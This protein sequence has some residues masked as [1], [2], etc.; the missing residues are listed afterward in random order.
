MTKKIGYACINMTLS[1]CFVKNNT[2][3]KVSNKNKIFTNRTLRKN[4]FSLEKVSDLILS[5]VKDLYTICNWNIKNNILLFRVSS[6]IFPFMDHPELQYELSELKDY[7]EIS[8]WLKLT[9]DMANSNNLRLT[10]HP[11]PYNCLG[12][13]NDYTVEKTILSLEMHRKLG[14]YLQQDDFVINVHV[15]GT[16]GGDFTNTSMRFCDNFQK[17][18]TQCQKWLTIEN[19]DKQS[20]W[21][22]S[23]LYNYIH[24]NIS[25]PIILDI[26]HW[27][28]CQDESLEKAFEI[29]LSTWGSRKP[30][31]HYS[32][33]ALGKRPQAHSDYI[34]KKIPDF[35]G[36]YDIMIEAK[37][38]EKAVL[39]YINKFQ[40]E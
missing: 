39:D 2:I 34:M 13:P 31:I 22:V 20:M 7:S 36:E 40:N 9:G 29:A 26:H 17:L 3:H 24:K 14:E 6:E 11:G 37:Q 8:N 28:F 27:Q 15:G 16:Y 10:S 33:S 5:N 12:S 25:V 35:G 32:E 4:N 21:S 19:D 23:K 38:K 1:D 30:K 18:S